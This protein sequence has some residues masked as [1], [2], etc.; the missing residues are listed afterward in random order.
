MELIVFVP[1]EVKTSGFRKAKPTE[2][3]ERQ[4][5]VFLVPLA[6]LSVWQPEV[7]TSGG[8][9]RILAPF[10]LGDGLG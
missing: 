8:K 4:P 5:I 2:G 7:L 6:D 3:A 10:H 1:P 9:E